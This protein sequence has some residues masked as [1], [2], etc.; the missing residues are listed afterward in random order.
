MEVKSLTNDE[1]FL[2]DHTNWSPEY[3]QE[4]ARITK[5]ELTEDHWLIIRAVRS[6][7]LKT[8]QSPS[9]RPLV[10]IVQ[11]CVPHLANS[12]S[13]VH[14]FSHEVTRVVA[15]ISGLPKPSDCL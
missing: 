11:G 1:G 6:F 8:G 13:L 10:N 7:Y 12:I 5:I 2:R 14:L 3:A 15:Q 9:M 4:V